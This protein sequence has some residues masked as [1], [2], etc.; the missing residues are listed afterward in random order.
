MDGGKQ[1]FDEWKL[2]ND[3][4]YLIDKAEGT[5]T[6]VKIF[7]I[8]WEVSSGII[9]KPSEGAWWYCRK[10]FDSE[11]DINKYVDTLSEAMGKLVEKKR[12]N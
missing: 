8:E 4:I 2:E 5:E 6:P 11:E 7:D 12:V 1:Y 9:V 10:K 3:Y